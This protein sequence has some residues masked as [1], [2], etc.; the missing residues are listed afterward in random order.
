[1]AGNLIWYS[2]F[3]VCLGRLAGVL[4]LSVVAWFHGFDCFVFACRVP[5]F[6]PI[7][8]HVFVMAGYFAGWFGFGFR[9]AKKKKE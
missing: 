7:F 6:S 5:S 2:F 8:A 4:P 3:Q 9:Y 1:M